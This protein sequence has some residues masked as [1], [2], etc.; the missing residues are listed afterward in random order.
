MSRVLVFIALVVMTAACSSTYDPHGLLDESFEPDYLQLPGSVVD[1]EIEDAREDTTSR[2]LSVPMLSFPWSDD[3]VE[4]ALTPAYRSFIESEINKYF[5]G[6]EELSVTVVINEGVKRFVANW[7]SEGQEA[8]CKLTIKIVR[9]G[10][11]LTGGALHGGATIKVQSFDAGGA[12][13][14]AMY[15]TVIAACIDQCM[16]AYSE[17]V[18]PNL[19]S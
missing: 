5:V 3:K 1:V 15:K 6:G 10:A 12:A 18:A 14:E 16:R 9:E 13:I 11:S 2:E 8:E 19:D 17:E 7:F 4:P